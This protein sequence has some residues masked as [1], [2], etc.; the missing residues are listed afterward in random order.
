MFDNVAVFENAVAEHFGE[1]PGFRLSFEKHRSGKMGMTAACR[2]NRREGIKSLGGGEH[3][4]LCR[5]MIK[6]EGRR[7]QAG[8][9]SWFVYL[10]V[11]QC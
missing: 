5:F 3:E 9:D 4:P 8:D 7:Q 6:A 10:V 11:T 2:R 1:D